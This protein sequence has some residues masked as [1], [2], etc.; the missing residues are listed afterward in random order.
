MR[1]TVKKGIEFASSKNIDY[2]T[3]HRQRKKDLGNILV[4]LG[5]VRDTFKRQSNCHQILERRASSHMSVN[6][7]NTP[8]LPQSAALKQLKK[9][10]SLS[11]VF[12]MDEDEHKSISKNL[13]TVMEDEST[14]FGFT[15]QFSL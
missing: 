10:Q 1:F 9:K 3:Q 2:R 13:E 14:D 5:T 4:R 7:L 8:S 6:P 15:N 12:S 11:E